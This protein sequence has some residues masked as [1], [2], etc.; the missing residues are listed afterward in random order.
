MQ[1]NLADVTDKLSVNFERLSSGL[2]I[3]SAKDDAVG[4]S[5]AKDFEA[6]AAV[7]AQAIQNVNEGIS[8]LNIASVATETLENI[9]TEIKEL[10]QEATNINTSH[11]RR[12]T[13]N[14]EANS[15]ITEY[16]RIVNTTDFNSYNLL[17]MSFENRS[18]QAGYGTESQINLSLA[19]DLARNVGD[20]TFSSDNTYAF[21]VQGTFGEYDNDVDIDGDG[22]LDLTGYIDQRYVFVA[23]GNGNGTFGPQISHDVSQFV[24]AGGDVAV[25]DLDND[26]VNDI[27][28]INNNYAHIL[29]GNG[30]GTF[31]T[32]VT[33]TIGGSGSYDADL[34]DFN[35]D[36]VL[37]FVTND[38]FA[39]ADLYVHIGNGDGTFATAT[40]H[41]MSGGAVL[42]QFV[43]D[44]NG[45][46]HADIFAVT[47]TDT[48]V[49]LGNGDGTFKSEI[50]STFVSQNYVEVADFDRD[51][52]LDHVLA[53]SP[54]ELIFFKGNGDGTFAEG[55]T[56]SVT[57]SQVLSVGDINDDGYYDLSTRTGATTGYLLG[58]GDGTFGS[59]NVVEANGTESVAIGDYNSDGA[60]D[61]IIADTALTTSYLSNTNQITTMPVLDLTNPNAARVSSDIASDAIERLVLERANIDAQIASLDINNVR[62]QITSE[63]YRSAA[64]QILDLDVAAETAELVRNQVIQDSASALLAQ[65]NQIPQL[66]LDLLGGI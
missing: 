29:I 1:R 32:L 5:V 30:D 34:A 48:S 22:N 58:N 12:L 55:V 44:F 45:D 59:Y 43:G 20:G 25:G 33:F 62:L 9:A 42:Q 11:S 28:A 13:L 52:E 6:D 23:L 37:D 65:A 63:Q 40:S 39:T 54:T 10:S 17:D 31:D 8:L 51:G 49:L 47:D 41:A 38:T 4:L 26:G 27:V 64:D 57:N 16:N 21:T 24:N 35:N 19:D 2:R 18:V 66:A 50:T 36:G 61:I 14:T 7:H 60:T 53:H 15:L 56:N 3:N 46:N